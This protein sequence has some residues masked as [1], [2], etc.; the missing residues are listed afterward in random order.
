M[1][2]PLSATQLDVLRA[3]SREVQLT[4]EEIQRE[5]GLAGG[6]PTVMRSLNQRGAIAYVG[7]RGV[8][9]GRGKWRLTAHGIDLLRQCGESPP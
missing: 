8:R 5:L 1:S 6:M 2:L 4:T 9:V 3:I 7:G